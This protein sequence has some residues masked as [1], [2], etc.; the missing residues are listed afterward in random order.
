MEGI[1]AIADALLTEKTLT[2]HRCRQIVRDVPPLTK[3][4]WQEGLEQI[5]EEE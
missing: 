4:E 2:A 5:D 1:E 3:E